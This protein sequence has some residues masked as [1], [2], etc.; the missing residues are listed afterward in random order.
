LRVEQF[1]EG[2]FLVHRHDLLAHVVGG[3]V[4]REG[5]A[6]L[7]RL[8]GQVADARGEPAG[9]DGD[10]PR[11]DAD[12]PV[13]VDDF[14]GLD[15]VDVVGERFAHAHE[16]DV[17]DLGFRGALGLE[18]LRDDFAGGEVALEALESAGAELAAVGAADLGGDAEGEAVGALAE[19]VERGGDEDAFDV[20]AGA[21]VPEEF[22]RGVVRALEAREGE[23]GE[24]VLRFQVRAERGGQ[25]GHLR[26]GGGAL[27]VEPFGELLAAV[28]PLV[29]EGPVLG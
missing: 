20:V 25:V 16:D 19:H 15:Q 7:Q 28:G 24:V 2:I 11:A 4:E 14:D 27:G 5:E 9:G 3:A 26:E 23:G 29:A 6:D 21:Q 18:D 1:G 10:V 8:I 13:R 12:A 22:A 17:V